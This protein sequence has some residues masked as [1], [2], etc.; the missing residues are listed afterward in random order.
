M[1][2]NAEFLRRIAKEANPVLLR[3]AV[4]QLAQLDKDHVSTWLGNMNNISDVYIEIYSIKKPD[5]VIN[6]EAY[7]QYG[8][9]DIYNKRFPKDI[10]R[11]KENTITLYSVSPDISPDIMKRDLQLALQTNV[12]LKNSIIVPVGM[13]GDSACLVRGTL[14]GL[15]LLYI[16]HH[17][18]DVDFIKVT[19]SDYRSLI[20]SYGVTSP[21]L[22]VD[23]ILNLFGSNVT[24]IVAVLMTIIKS[25]PIKPIP[26]EQLRE[27]NEKA[28]LILKSA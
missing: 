5:A 21:D 27:I 13:K 28:R 19:I 22:T 17:K 8:L 26:P 23:D 14:F 25:L 20:S 6:E 9:T 1:A 11:T 12:S 24:K 7:S 3:V 16:L 18:E 2:N 4:E 15:R 10:A